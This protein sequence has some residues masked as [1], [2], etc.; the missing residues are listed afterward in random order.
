MTSNLFAI[1]H[2]NSLNLPIVMEISNE[3]NF[4]VLCNFFPTD[5]AHLYDKN[6]GEPIC[7]Y[8]VEDVSWRNN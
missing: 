8:S 1:F 4:F 2:H 7:S 5:W 3:E 6:T